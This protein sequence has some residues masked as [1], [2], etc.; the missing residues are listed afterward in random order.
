MLSATACPH[1]IPTG[2]ELL[3]PGPGT[4]AAIDASRCA[5]NNATRAGYSLSRMAVRG[6]EIER[7]RETGLS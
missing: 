4:I 5:V 6:Y 2:M 7:E 1:A 3:L